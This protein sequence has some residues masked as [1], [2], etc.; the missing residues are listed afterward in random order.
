MIKLIVSFLLTL[1]VSIY[2]IHFTSIDGNDAAFSSFEGKK[3]LLVNIATGSNKVTQLGRLEQLYEQYHDSLV[4]IAFPS[5]SFGNEA[6]SNV[7]IK[8]F[9]EGTYHT[10]FFL[11][12]KVNI[13]GES[14]DSIY[15]WLAIPGD[16]GSLTG[17]V[18][19]DFQKFL[20]DKDGTLIGAFAPEVDPLDISITSAITGQSN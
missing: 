15:H 20:I 12:G 14:M 5:N 6:R 18:S 10:T 7:E 4:V 2:T 11:A 9:C 1:Q 3:I 19:G 13:T 17:T 8:S 16:N